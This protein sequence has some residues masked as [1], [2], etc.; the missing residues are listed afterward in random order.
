MQDKKLH[1]RHLHF[2]FYEQNIIVQSTNLNG[3]K[4]HS[5][6]MLPLKEGSNRH[7]YFP[8]SCWVLLPICQQSA[9][10]IKMDKGEEV[11]HSQK[12]YA[13]CALC[14]NSKLRNSA[15]EPQ[16]AWSKRRDNRKPELLPRLKTQQQ[17]AGRGKV[18]PTKETADYQLTVWR[19]PQA[20]AIV[21]F[22][23]PVFSWEKVW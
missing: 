23:E 11:A 15:C 17:R 14:A 2:Y 1:F 7:Q 6:N 12:Q 18:P 3:I 5:K 9:R 20:C 16:K 8:K 19:Y 22:S 4:T 13:A 21:I 10:R